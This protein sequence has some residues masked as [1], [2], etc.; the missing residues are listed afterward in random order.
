[1]IWMGMDGYMHLMASNLVGYAVFEPRS[2]G[3]P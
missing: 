2:M 3:V 1:M